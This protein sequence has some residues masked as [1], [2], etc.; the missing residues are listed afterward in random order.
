MSAPES[1]GDPEVMVAFAL[2]WQM[3]VLY[4]PGSWPT[5]DAQPDADL[6]GLGELEGSQRA[7]LGLKQVERGPECR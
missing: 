2:G 6:P 7:D 5:K 3:S 4:N 1:A